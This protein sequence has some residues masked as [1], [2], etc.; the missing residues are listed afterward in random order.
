[1]ILI[2]TLPERA[3]KLKS[4]THSLDKQLVEGVGYKIHDAGRGLP[5]GTKRN[6]LIEQ[7]QSEY[8]SFIDDDDQVSDEYVKEIMKALESSPDV[9]TFN[10]YLTT[11][12][13]HR[14]NF[15]IKLGSRYEERSGH[16]YRWPNHLCVFKRDKVRH[17][18]FPDVWNQEDYHWSKNIHD[19]K[20]LKTEVHIDKDLYWYKFETNKPSY[21]S[22]PKLR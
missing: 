1:M 22:R 9:V 11:N 8:F 16:Y 15:T 19:R 17:I 6:H 18:K 14:R 21:A 12:G 13:M 3:S 20:L 5:T 4:L 10:G 2:C 7:T